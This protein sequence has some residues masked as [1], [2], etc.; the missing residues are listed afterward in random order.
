M[1]QQQL[2]CEV[3]RRTGETLD[4]VRR[5]GFSHHSRPNLGRKIRLETRRKRRD[6]AAQTSR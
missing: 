3:A 4:T 1:T 5:I 2:E 6:Q